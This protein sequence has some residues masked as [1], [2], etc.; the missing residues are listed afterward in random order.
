MRNEWIV[1]V[2]SIVFVACPV[3]IAIAY[4]IW[5]RAIGS[6][7]SLPEISPATN[8]RL[9]HLE[10]SVDVVAVEVERVSENVRYL[11][12]LLAERPAN[13]GIGSGGEK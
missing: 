6:P 11:T 10:R 7:A 5:R 4:W 2:V 9:E 13:A 12:K 8:Q 3:S 1:E